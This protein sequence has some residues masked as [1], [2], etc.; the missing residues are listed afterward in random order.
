MKPILFTFPGG[1][2]V[3]AFGVMLGLSLVVGFQ[4]TVRL[5]NRDD[6]IDR[7]LSGNAA[8][9]AVLVGLLG[10]RL[11]YVAINAE[12]LEDTPMQWW[13]IQAGGLMG[14]G[15]LLSGFAA[16]ALYLR[17]KGASVM[18][19]A[20][21]AAPGI[22]CGVVLTRIGSYLYGSD[23][24]TRLTEGSTGLLATLGTFPHWRDSELFGSPA[25]AHHVE[26]YGLSRN[27]DASY[28][29]HPVQLYCVALGLVLLALALYTRKHRSYSGQ[30]FVRTALGYAAFAFVLGYLRDDPD[31]GVFF[32]FTTTQLVSLLLFPVLL[33]ARTQLRRVETPGKPI[34]N[35]HPEAEA[36]PPAKPQRET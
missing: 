11:A 31:R 25:F 2:P 23:F 12:L 16:A 3:Y 26:S 6:H 34:Q 13:N 36:D 10:A 24:G 19:V 18:A 21:A 8:L 32:D 35:E 7:D 28:P 29:V 5:A 14:V 17:L 33:I 15:G 20:D 22:A 30:V 1:Y 9:F 4:L 27:A